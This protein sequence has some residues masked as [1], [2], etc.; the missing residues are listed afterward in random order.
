MYI[1]IYIY[2]YIKYVY[3]YIYIYIERERERER[4]TYIHI[5]DWSPTRPR[6]LTPSDGSQTPSGRSSYARVGACELILSTYP[7]DPDPEIRPNKSYLELRFTYVLY[8][9]NLKEAVSGSGSL[10]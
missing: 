1:Y 10:S 4:D 7:R 5:I 6:K 3:I 8:F 2:I 9:L